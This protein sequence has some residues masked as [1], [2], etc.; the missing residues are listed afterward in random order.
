[1]KVLIGLPW[2]AIGLINA[3]ISAAIGLGCYQVGLFISTNYSTLWVLPI[4]ANIFALI[5]AL[6]A[7]VALGFILFGVA[8]SLIALIEN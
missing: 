3:L 4:I 2:I 1:M 7:L 6:Y 8:I 5:N